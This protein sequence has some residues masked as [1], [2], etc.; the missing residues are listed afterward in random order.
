MKLKGLVTISKITLADG[1]E[2]STQQAVDY[3]WIT[4]PAGRQPAGWGLERHEVNLGENLFL[5]Q[6]RQMLAFAFGYR[7]PIANYTVANFAVGTGLTP[8]RVTDVALEAPIPLIVGGKSQMYKPID[9]VDF[10]SPFIVRVGFTLGTD[11]ANGYMITEM[12]LLSGGLALIA[13]KIR[14]VGI[15]K[16]NNFSPTLT[17]RLRF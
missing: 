8:A 1:R 9:V 3:G 14:N 4:V 16:S 12:G 5:D 10:L 6:G 15:N 13:R 2:I 17:W 11:D 7:S